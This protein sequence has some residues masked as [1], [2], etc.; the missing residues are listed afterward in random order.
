MCVS[1]VQNIDNIY[2]TNTYNYI[3]ICT[4]LSFIAVVWKLCAS[5]PGD[6]H[7]VRS[8]EEKAKN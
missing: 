7:V 6:S 5:N 1:N 2:S 8:F 4:H 3:H